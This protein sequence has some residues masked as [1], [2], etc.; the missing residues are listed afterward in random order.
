MV[1]CMLIYEKIVLRIT[2]MN[3]YYVFDALHLLTIVFLLVFY[4]EV[5][6]IWCICGTCKVQD[7]F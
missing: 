2:P 4:Q 3:N 5:M 6:I 1:I 7:G